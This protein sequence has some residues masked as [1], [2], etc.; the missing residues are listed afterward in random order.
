MLLPVPPIHHFTST[1]LFRL[2]KK[3][4]KKS[5][6]SLDFFPVLKVAGGLSLS[7]P[8]PSLAPPALSLPIGFI[9][10]FSSRAKSIEALSPSLSVLSLSVRLCTYQKSL[11]GR[12]C[13]K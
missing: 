3:K 2:P 5:F 13:L 6:F 10:D 1:P 12:L 4:G 9:K 8:R 11:V 7:F